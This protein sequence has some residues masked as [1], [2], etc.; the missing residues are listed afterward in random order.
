MSCN[1][2]NKTS[3]DFFPWAGIVSHHNLAREYIDKWFFY[4]SKTRYPK[5]FFII[6]PDHYK[7]SLQHYSLT[8]GFWKTSFGVVESDVYI[9]REMKD[10]LNIDLDD[11]V[12]GIE[13]GV[14]TII[15]YIKKYFPDSKV[16][17]I[18]TSGDSE[19]NTLTAG[20]LADVLENYFDDEGKIENFLI[21]SSDFSHNGN[22]I[23]T[24][25]NDELSKKYLLNSA[26]V[27]WNT[28]ICDNR[29]GIFVLDRLGKKKMK[30]RIIFHTNSMEI[31]GYDQDIT[32]Y[33]FTFF[34]DIK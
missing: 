20:Y 6:S 18:V 31:S 34:G 22:L 21:I 28:V 17:V 30:S 13:H 14:Y 12:F 9:V 10:Q 2:N 5:R 23:E 33:F 11:R 16:V 26:D 25:I 1:K 3:G 29:A 32:S 15:P 19:V 4:L 8:E 24:N 7:L 27:S